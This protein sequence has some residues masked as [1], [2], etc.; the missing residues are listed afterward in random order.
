MI[1]RQKVSRRWF[2]N[3]GM[4]ALLSQ[5]RLFEQRRDAD[6]HD[7]D[8]DVGFGLCSA[9][10]LRFDQLSGEGFVSDISQRCHVNNIAR[11]HPTDM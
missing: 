2:R 11:R 8:D 7:D 6:D 3:A 4:A 9:M 1:I 10:P 5:W